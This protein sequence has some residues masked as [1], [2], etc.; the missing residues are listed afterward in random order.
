MRCA[1]VSDHDR[2]VCRR[3][4]HAPAIA[5]VASWSATAIAATKARDLV[6]KR[7][8]ARDSSP[9]HRRRE[10]MPCTVKKQ[11]V[12]SWCPVGFEC[13]KTSNLRDAPSREAAE[14]ALRQHLRFNPAHAEAGID[15]ATIE[16]FMGIAIYRSL[17]KNVNSRYSRRPKKGDKDDGQGWK[18][19]GK[20]GGSDASRRARVCK[21]SHLRSRAKQQRAMEDNSFEINAIEQDVHAQA[22]STTKKKHSV[23]GSLASVRI[24]GESGMHMDGS[25]A[26]FS[27]VNSSSMLTVDRKSVGRMAYNELA[28]CN[29]QHNRLLRMAI[30]HGFDPAGVKKCDHQ[31]H[32]QVIEVD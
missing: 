21:R 10:A 32:A 30:Y 11:V 27:I 12:R 14:Q 19:I 5:T 26:G 9:L 3:N 16:D 23:S 18:A 15:E 25:S 1:L 2:C 8:G 6:V 24:G 4:L 13:G 31:N 7:L 28:E 29:C 17:D 20:G 22:T